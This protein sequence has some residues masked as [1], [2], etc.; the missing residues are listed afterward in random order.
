MTS[1]SVP[2]LIWGMI[3]QRTGTF[4]DKLLQRKSMLKYDYLM[5]FTYHQM[6]TSG[7]RDKFP[8]ANCLDIFI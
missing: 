2:F 7:Q 5:F 4:W 8:N 3:K 6:S 1:H